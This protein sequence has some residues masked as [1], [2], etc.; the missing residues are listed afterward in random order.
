MEKAVVFGAGQFGKISLEKLK[1][2]YDVVAFADNNAAS[3][4][5]AVMG[6][7]VISPKELPAMNALVFI[8]P[9]R[10]WREIAEQLDG[11]G[12][13]YV[14]LNA[15]LSYQLIDYRIYPFRVGNLCPYKKSRRGSFPCCLFSSVSAPE[16]T[17]L[18]PP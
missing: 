10:Y 14:V 6:L 17:K 15:F 18:P 5:T 8:T 13:R 12:V 4:G 3:W 2:V 11:L 16:R 9:E 7:P 1:F